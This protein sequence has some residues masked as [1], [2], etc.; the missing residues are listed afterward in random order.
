MKLSSFY[1]TVALLMF[2][3]QFL[4]AQKKAGSAINL[5]LEEAKVY[6]LTKS[7]K[8]INAKL[9]LTQAIKRKWEATAD[10]LPQVNIGV[11]YQ[12]QIEQ[13]V[14]LVP[15]EIVGGESGTFVPLIFGTKQQANAN[16]TVSQLIFDGSFLI[17]LKAAKSFVKY[18]KE[19]HKRTEQEIKRDVVNTYAAVLLAQENVKIVENNIKALEKNLDE[20][21]SLLQNGMIE[22]ENVELLQVTLIEVNNQLS[23]AKRLERTVKQIFNLLIGVDIDQ[24]VLLMDSLSSLTVKSLD[25]RISGMKFDLTQNSTYKLSDQFTKGSKLAYVLEKNRALPSIQAFISYNNAAF[26]NEFTFFDSSTQWFPSSILGVQLNWPLFTSFGRG[27]KVKRSKLAYEQ[28]KNNFEETKQQILLSYY[29]ARSD[30]Q[31]SIENFLASKK[32]LELS[33][34][35][36]E[37]NQ[38]KY[39][40]GLATSF[41]LRQAQLQLYTA[42]QQ[43][44]KSMSDLI[45][46]KT[47][48]E[49][50]INN[51]DKS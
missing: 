7:Y 19:L 35:I 29:N 30:Y 32:K 12:N 17:S 25:D 44:L 46:K 6:A 50:I 22:E 23:E 48:L 3:N 9:E 4:V 37:K 16:I 51:K 11:N 27:A 41:E 15:G 24:D 2:L 39:A 28:A 26:E 34:T 40:E 42:Q 10:G 5:T 31:L 1:Y 33:E 21:K 38:I 36:E 47:E 8:S 14:N 18:N 13:P 45:S 20:T 43:F 49:T